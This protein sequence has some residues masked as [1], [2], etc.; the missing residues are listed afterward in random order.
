MRPVRLIFPIAQFIFLVSF[1]ER[2]SAQVPVVTTEILSGYLLA[3]S[4]YLVTNRPVVQTDIFLPSPSGVFGD[5]WYSHQLYEPTKFFGARGDE[6]DLT[7]GWLGAIGSYLLKAQGAWWQIA[8]PGNNF[9]DAKATLSRS[10]GEWAPFIGVEDQLQIPRDKHIAMV[11]GGTDVAFRL[12]AFPFQERI[13]VS[14]LD[15]GRLTVADVIST[16]IEFG[17]VVARPIL[18]VSTDDRQHGTFA[19]FGLRFVL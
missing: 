13:T 9:G 17:A 19:T 12:F 3:E 5:L 8:G 11:H 6:L 2:I 7:G 10:L 15:V 16:T 1:S 14:W 4:N 18:R